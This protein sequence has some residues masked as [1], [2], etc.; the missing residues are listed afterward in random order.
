MAD[1]DREGWLNG[2]RRSGDTVTVDDNVTCCAGCGRTLGVFSITIQED[3]TPPQLPEPDWPYNENGCPLCE[4]RTRTAKA[5]AALAW[6]KGQPRPL[7]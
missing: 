6:R 2:R 3:Y 7:P 4:L 5:E 1:S